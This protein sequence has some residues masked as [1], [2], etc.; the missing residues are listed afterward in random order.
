VTQTLDPYGLPRF[1][2]EENLPG[3]VDHSDIATRTVRVFTHG[4]VTATIISHPGV[5]DLIVSDGHG[6]V[7]FEVLPSSDIGARLR[8]IAG[9]IAHE[10]F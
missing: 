2:G 4:S 5:W 10:Q 9:A 8:A 6:A 3:W 1:D 7:E